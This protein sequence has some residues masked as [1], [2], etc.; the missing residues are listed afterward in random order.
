[1]TTTP[2]PRNLRINFGAM[3]P[4]IEEQLEEQGLGLDLEPVQ[5]MH[6]QRDIDEVSRLR[7][8]CVLTEAESDKARKRIFQFIKKHVKPL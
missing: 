2:T 1:M 6:L 4:R 8:R 7:V 3:S 5:R